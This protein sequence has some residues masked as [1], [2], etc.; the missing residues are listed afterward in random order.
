MKRI[1]LTGGGSAGH[2]TPNLALI[3]GLA[4]L[5]YEVHYIGTA[6][7]IERKLVEAAGVSY[8]A[9]AAGKLRRYFSWRNFTD[10]FRVV[11]GVGQAVTTL[12]R[13]APNVV[14][15]KGGFVSLPVVVAARTMG[16]PVVIHESDLTPGLANRLAAPFADRICYTFPETQSRL[17]ARKGVLTGIP[18]RDSLTRGDAAVGRRFLGLGSER[19]LVTVVGGSLGARAVNQAVHSALD[20]LLGRYRVCHIC[21]KGGLDPTL[22]GR[23]GYRQFEYLE[24]DL[25]AVFAATDLFVSRAGATTLFEML[26]LRK[27]ALLVPL[28]T[29]GSRG[30]QILNADSFEKQGYCRVLRQEDL[31]PQSL[32]TGIASLYASRDSIVAAMS[33]SAVVDARE[34]VLQVIQSVAR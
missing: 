4:G 8:H 34:A 18:V 20:L 15:A 23:P 25:P 10:P 32:A 19:P 14:F 6:D 3:P 22:E 28:S 16:I 12:K 29:A 11:A 13:L 21:G 2:V 17:P 24:A 27:P 33:A 1:V 7:G 9:I 30:D 26:A 5:G 31:T